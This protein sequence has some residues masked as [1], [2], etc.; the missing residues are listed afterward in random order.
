MAKCLS[1]VPNSC[2]TIC[3]FC[4][5]VAEEVAADDLAR[6]IRLAC[7]LLEDNGYEVRKVMTKNKEVK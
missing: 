4:K 7:W 6:N 2:E 5:K 1:G 3:S